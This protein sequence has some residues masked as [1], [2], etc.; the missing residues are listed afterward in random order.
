MVH[1]LCHD[2]PIENPYWTIGCSVEVKVTSTEVLLVDTS[3][4]HC[5]TV[6]AELRAVLTPF[7]V[8]DYKE[9]TPAEKPYFVELWDVGGWSAHQNSR[10]IFYNPVHGK[11]AVTFPPSHLFT[12]TQ[13]IE[14]ACVPFRQTDRHTD[15]VCCFLLQA[16]SWFMISQIENLSRIYG[17]GWQKCSTGIQRTELKSK[18]RA[19]LQENLSCQDCDL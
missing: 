16:L 5:N 11:L 7:Q 1:L 14:R 9:G 2:E 3:A 17:N 4:Q 13:T 6:C 10:S 15:L 12:D 19:H 18:L 8:H